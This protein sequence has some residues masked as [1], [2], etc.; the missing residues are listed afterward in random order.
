MLR[1]GFNRFTAIRLATALAGAVFLWAS[2]ASARIA[3][4]DSS[5]IIDADTGQVLSEH[6]ADAKAYPASLT[7]MMT[8]YL[9]FEALE[10]GRI[11]LDQS[12]R[13][14][15]H[16]QNQAPSKLGLVDGQTVPFHD[17]ILGLITRSAND[18]AVVVAE[19]L[20][21]S[22][23]NFADRMTE[24]ARELDMTNTSY[25]NASGLPNPGQ[26]TTARDLA[27]LAQ[28]LYRDFPKEYALFATEEFTYKGSTYVN[29]N[30]LMQ[31]FEGM[32]GIKTGYIRASGFNLAASAV[33]NNRRLIGVV[34]GGRS[35]YARDTEMAQLLNEGFGGGAAPAI[36][37]AST[38]TEDEPDATVAD[39]ARRTIA[40]LSPVGR[41]EA[42]IPTHA[43]T[44]RTRH[45][46][47]SIQVGAFSDEEPAARAAAKAL[48]R[49]PAPRGKST[50]VLA[51]AH[52][53]KEPVYRARIVN[54]TEREATKACRTL[55]RKHLQCSVVAPGTVQQAALN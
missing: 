1:A 34:M 53:D 10:A 2:P 41:A 8:L 18:A 49:L 11:T 55:H 32:D 26:L 38:T 36:A 15:H 40:S 13:V 29:H 4:T 22:E 45:G 5:I 9:A 12:V 46:G 48:A 16:A 51:P 30:R 20:A 25:R 39:R 19:A 14:S 33:R 3:K 52:I 17:L 28:A 44:A 24:K 7:K 21:G 6:N 47:W 31:S 42:A 54:F 27:K 37:T 35:A 23:R 50:L 43:R